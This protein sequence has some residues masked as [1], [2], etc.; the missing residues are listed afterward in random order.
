METRY[1]TNENGERVGVIL[2]M[3]EYGRLLEALED[4][5]DLKAADEALE[6]IERGEED[7]LPFTE[8]VHEM[9]EERRQL[10]EAGK[11]PGEPAETG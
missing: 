7:L 8:A 2:G 5:E 11:F 9:D 6:A 4:L 1:V 10:R 3:E